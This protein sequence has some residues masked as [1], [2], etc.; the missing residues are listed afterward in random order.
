MAAIRRRLF[1]DVEGGRDKI[2]LHQVQD[3]EEI[4]RI[5]ELTR[6]ANGSGTSSFWKGRHYVKIASIPLVLIDQWHRQ[7]INFYDPNDWPKIK[8]MLNDRDYEALRTAPGRI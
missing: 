1:R 4:K 7:G 2:V 5:N 8:A 3:V 6:L